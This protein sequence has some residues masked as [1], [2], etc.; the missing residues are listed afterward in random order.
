MKESRKRRQAI[1]L[2]VFL[3]LRSF[4]ILLFFGIHGGP[5]VKTY[6][7][8]ALRGGLTVRP[9]MLG[10]CREG[11]VAGAAV[12]REAAPEGAAALRA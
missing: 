11:L 4:P 6:Y 3:F 1:F 5:V 7:A 9:R 2:T 8:A 10:P 12:L